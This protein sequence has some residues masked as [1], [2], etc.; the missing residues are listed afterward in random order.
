MTGRPDR[1]I[2]STPAVCLLIHHLAAWVVKHFEIS[3][4]VSSKM[5]DIEDFDANFP[6]P[7]DFEHRADAV[8]RTWQ[9]NVRDGKDTVAIDVFERVAIGQVESLLI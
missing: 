2:I 6:C 1:G 3:Q 5:M 8:D 9:H 7:K 4:V